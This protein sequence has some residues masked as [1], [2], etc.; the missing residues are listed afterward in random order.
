MRKEE[1]Y[2]EL[3][4]DDKNLEIEKKNVNVFIRGATLTRLNVKFPTNLITLHINKTRIEDI[5]NV[6]FLSLI[7]LEELSLYDNHIVKFTNPIPDK[8]TELNLSHN[9][10]NY[11]NFDPK[12][13]EKLD[14]Q[15]NFLKEIPD[16]LHETPNYININYSF[17]SFDDIITNRSVLVEINGKKIKPPKQDGQDLM[18]EFNRRVKLNNVPPPRYKPKKREQREQRILNHYKDRMKRKQNNV[19]ETEIQSASRLAIKNLIKLQLNPTKDS[20]S[21]LKKYYTSRMSILYYIFSSLFKNDF[22]KELDYFKKANFKYTYDYENMSSVTFVELLGLVHSY[23]ET[24]EDKH[25]LYESLKFQIIDGIGYCQTG[26][27]TRILGALISSSDI[28]KIEKTTNEKISDKAV[29]LKKLYPDDEEKCK[30]ELKNYMNTL[31]ICPVE[32]TV[33]LEA[34]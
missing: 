19:H 20:I 21:S 33:W 12:N 24:Q 6:N 30:N 9:K 27:V 15:N 17:N 3:T 32:Q 11:V 14:L 4:N 18:K 1:E 26:K 7:H 29:E 10:I 13:L 22:Y 8:L 16:C 25:D 31:N 34:F 5:S 28:M 23:I 2:Q